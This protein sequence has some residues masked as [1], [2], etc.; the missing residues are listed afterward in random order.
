M[1][2]HSPDRPY[3]STQSVY[4]VGT[5]RSGAPHEKGAT[6]R[7][8]AGKT[9]LSLVAVFT[10]VS[11]YVA[12][13]NET[14]VLNPLWPPH[15]KFHNGQ[16]MAMG[17]LLAVATLFFVWRRRGDAR[18]NLFAAVGFAGLYWVSQA[19]AILY[20]GAAYFDPQFDTADMYLAGLPVQ[21]VIEIVVLALIA[22]SVVLCRPTRLE[23]GLPAVPKG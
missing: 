21:A 2:I 9:L 4:A 12:D 17:T 8:T 22:G 11:P 5:V 6:T 16:T 10:A 15:A 23:M 20:P 19:A 18:S 13:W 7:E 3:D 1:P 14:H